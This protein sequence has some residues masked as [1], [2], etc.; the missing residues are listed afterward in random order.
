MVLIFSL[1]WIF[2]LFEFSFFP[3]APF[4][5]VSRRQLQLTKFYGHSP[6][7]WASFPRPHLPKISSKGSG[8]ELKKWHENYPDWVSGLFDF[9]FFG[10]DFRSKSQICEKDF[11]FWVW[12]FVGRV[13]CEMTCAAV[14]TSSHW[15]MSGCTPSRWTPFLHIEK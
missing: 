6:F 5:P 7:R 1:C 4:G 15:Y 12:F 14:E 9:C 3:G 13:Q 2:L 8:S 10:H 11:G